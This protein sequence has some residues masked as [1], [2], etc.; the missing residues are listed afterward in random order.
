MDGFD[1]PYHPSR[2]TL[3]KNPFAD[4]FA[5]RSA[6]PDP[7]RSYG[8]QSP[9]DPYQPY[10]SFQEERSTT[11]PLENEPS[12]SRVVPTVPEPEVDPLDS[13][14]ANAEPEEE[15]TATPSTPGFKE[16]IGDD[17]E[18]VVLPTGYS[19]TET[20]RNLEPEEIAK[21]A[22]PV[23]PQ[24]SSLPKQPTSPRIPSSPPTARPSTSTY[25]P[26][27]SAAQ[28]QFNSILTPLDQN[29]AKLENSFA[30]LAIGGES[31]SGWQGSHGGW[32]N[33]TPAVSSIIARDDEEDRS[34][35]SV[36]VVSEGI[37]SSPKATPVRQ[38]H[39]SI[40]IRIY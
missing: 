29:P 26:P 30:S 9:E 13:A 16:S 40:S 11:P 1:D 37:F 32:V 20:I 36:P 7:W 12:G 8:A 33:D 18:S 2:D 15:A 21:P 25:S 17:T 5:K 24:Q 31:S 4:P 39:S 23:P 34:V 3:E 35:D 14:A 6:S 22:E 28:S 10:S 38:S 27:P 19:Q